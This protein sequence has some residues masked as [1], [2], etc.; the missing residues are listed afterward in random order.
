MCIQNGM[1]LDAG[2]RIRVEVTPRDEFQ[3][4]CSSQSTAASKV[5]RAFMREFVRQHASGMQPSLFSYAPSGS[6]G[7]V[8]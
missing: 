7:I 8:S 2:L 4:A 5:I 3:T 1:N 6:R